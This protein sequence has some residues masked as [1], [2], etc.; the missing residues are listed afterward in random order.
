MN[1]NIGNIPAIISMKPG[2]VLA[3]IVYGSLYKQTISPF[4]LPITS[5]KPKDNIFNPFKEYWDPAYITQAEARNRGVEICLKESNVK[6]A[7]FQDCDVILTKDTAIE[8]AINVLKSNKKIGVVYFLT[9]DIKGN[10]ID[11]IQDH[12]F[13]ASLIGLIDVFKKIKFRTDTQNICYCRNFYNDLILEGYTP[14]FLENKLI[15]TE[16]NCN[17]GSVLN[18]Y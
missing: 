5:D 18:E 11:K 7:Y 16:L 3:P 1:P 2:H 15:G 17:N 12:Y 9:K 6:Y 10:F 4:I 8:D 14:I 13:V